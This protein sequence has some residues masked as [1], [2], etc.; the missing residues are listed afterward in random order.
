MD[1]ILQ[2]GKNK[3]EDIRTDLSQAAGKA[4]ARA[5]E[6]ISAV[7]EGARDIASDLVHKAP[8]A[9]SAAVHKTNEGIAAVGHQMTALGEAVRHGVT[10]GGA[11]APTATA[12]ADNLQ[13]GGRYLEGHGLQEMGQ[14]VTSLIRRYPVQSLLASFGLGCLLGMAWRRR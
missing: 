10:P 12:V 7:A 4:K 9:A 2:D 13:A 1:N 8:E 6:V 5:Q 14:D 11:L 3:L